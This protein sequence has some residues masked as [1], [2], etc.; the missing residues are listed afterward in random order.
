MAADFI[1]VTSFN[2]KEKVFGFYAEGLE[3][4]KY[5]LPLGELDE[6]DP[7]VAG[8]FRK[9]AVK[10][11]GEIAMSIKQWRN[12]VAAS[13]LVEDEE[14][15]EDGGENDDAEA[16]ETDDDV[17]DEDSEQLSTNPSTKKGSKTMAKVKALKAKTTR[18]ID[19]EELEETEDEDETEVAEADEDEDEDEES[20]DE[21][22]VE[23]VTK[24]TKKVTK[25]VEPTPEPV[26]TTKAE[27]I[28]ALRKEMRGLRLERRGI[29]ENM[30]LERERRSEIGATLR[31]MRERYNKLRGKAPKAA[32]ATPAPAKKV[33]TARKK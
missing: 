30:K 13:E 7:M 9:V 2:K 11:T 17:D 8:D 31:K 21:E 22:E 27:K 12:T 15:E 10:G 25:V 4:K 33:V 32:A 14:D 5:I 6:L 26:P 28:K 29:R 24:T 20:E 3:A 19:E 1:I 23:V 18:E 16:D